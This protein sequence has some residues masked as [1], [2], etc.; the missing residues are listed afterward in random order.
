[1][2]AAA[3]CFTSCSVTTPPAPEGATSARSTPIFFAS[4]R[5]AG[6]ALTPPAPVAA[7]LTT[8]SLASIAPTT[9]PLSARSALP[10][11]AISPPSS[12]AMTL[13]L[14]SG[15]GVPTGVFGAAVA[16]AAS[17]F[18]FGAWWCPV[19]SASAR[20]GRLMSSSTST[21]GAP[22]LDHVAGLAVQLGDLAGVGR[23]HLD[24]GL[25]GLHRHH[26]LVQHH[27]VAFLHQPLDDFR[28]RQAFAEVGEMKSL[29]RCHANPVV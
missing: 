26:G 12:E 3:A 16:G 1:V 22:G 29:S 9:V 8:R 25:G 5:T 19:D 13:A 17:A 7:S 6:T 14:S 11:A 4:A 18:G 24:H 2:P 27:G 15:A 21:S 23:G 10:P 28:V 20:C